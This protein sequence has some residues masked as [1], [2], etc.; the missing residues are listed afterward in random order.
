MHWFIDCELGF[1]LA[2]CKNVV[3]KF[4]DSAVFD[5]ETFS[6]VQPNLRCCYAHCAPLERGLEAP[7]FYRHTAPLERKKENLSFSRK[8]M[9]FFMRRACGHLGV[10]YSVNVGCVPKAKV[11]YLSKIPCTLHKVLGSMN[12][13]LTD[14]PPGLWGFGFLGNRCC[15]TPVAPLRLMENDV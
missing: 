6:P 10:A 4:R 5:G 8:S 11:I 9:S 12:Q 7:S 1:T 15:Y 2:I 3:L 14:S 13:E